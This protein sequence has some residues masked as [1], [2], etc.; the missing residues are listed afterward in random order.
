MQDARREELI[1]DGL[2]TVAAAEKFSD[3]KKSFLYARMADGSLPYVKVGAAR[4]IPKRAL[5]EF[6][7]R[8]LVLR[9]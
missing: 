5:I 9:D 3:L 8:N 7:A 4:R 1:A 2:M 6:L